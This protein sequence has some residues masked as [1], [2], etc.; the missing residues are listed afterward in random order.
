[1]V[2]SIFGQLLKFL[3]TSFVLLSQIPCKT[4]ESTVLV[5]LKNSPIDG[6][7]KLNRAK[8]RHFK[9]FGSAAKQF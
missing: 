5:K 6:T 2:A 9:P 1:M 3:Q 7:I 8:P 4:N